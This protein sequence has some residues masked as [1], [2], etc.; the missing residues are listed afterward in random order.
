MNTIEYK[1][2]GKCAR[3]EKNGRIM[4]VTLDIGPRIIY[5]GTENRNYLNEDIERNVSNGGEYFDREFG[6]GSKWF[7]YGGHRVWKSPEDMETYVPDN[8]AVDADFDDNG[9]SFTTHCAKNF[10]YTLK[11]GLSEDGVASVENIVTNK[12][13]EAREISVWALTVAAKGGTL[14]VPLNEPKDGLNPCQNIVHWPYN[15]LH[16]ERMFF[17]KKFLALRQTDKKDALKIGLFAEKNKAVYVLGDGAL[18]FVYSRKNGVFGDFWCNFE[19]YTNAHILEIEALSERVSLLKGQG[20]SLKMSMSVSEGS[21][22]PEVL[23]DDNLSEF[24]QNGNF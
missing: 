14:I 23:D 13:C 11:V 5:F 20:A 19:T 8:R 18:K 21:P 22:L 24:W 1:N 2:Y 12:G 16:D 9:G 4:L 17:G 6:Q 15:D 3:F 7:L 10:D